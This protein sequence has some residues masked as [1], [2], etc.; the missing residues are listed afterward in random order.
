MQFK[1]SSSSFFQFFAEIPLVDVKE[2]PRTRPGLQSFR[3]HLIMELL[4]LQQAIDSRKNVRACLCLLVRGVGFHL[5]WDGRLVCCPQGWVSA[6]LV[7]FCESERKEN[8]KGKQKLLRFGC[9]LSSCPA[10]E[11]CYLIRIVS[12]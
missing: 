7:F 6:F 12:V 2:L 3:N 8:G 5:Q 11:T 9:K 10:T 4:W 1:Y